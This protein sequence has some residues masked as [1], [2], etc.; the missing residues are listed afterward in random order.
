MY[1]INFKE[2]PNFQCVVTWPRVQ[3]RQFDTNHSML[4][5]WKLCCSYNNYSS[6]H[7]IWKTMRFLF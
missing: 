5:T 6:L 4:F 1:E 2:K 3:A 7:F